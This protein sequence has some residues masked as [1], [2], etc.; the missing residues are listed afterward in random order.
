MSQT[1]LNDFTGKRYRQT[2]LTDFGIV[3]EKRFTNQD[4]KNLTRAGCALAG[5]LA[6]LQIFNSLLQA[7]EEDEK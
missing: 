5:T 2:S 3:A 1:T 4:R 7:L 6:G